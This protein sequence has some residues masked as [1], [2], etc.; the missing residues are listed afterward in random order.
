M[1][2]HENEPQF[3]VPKLLFNIR[4][5]GADPSR[6][7][8]RRYEF[9]A[10]LP[11]DPVPA[12]RVDGRIVSYAKQPGRGI[13]RH[14]M[15]RPCLQS[16]EHSFLHGLLGQFEMSRSEEPRQVGQY[17]PRLMPEQV[18]QQVAMF[19]RRV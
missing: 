10:L 13:L 7:V 6:L 14:S 3:V 19:R 12:N 9:G 4:I 5:A 17:P 18:L 1:A 16:A 11:S 2:A 15:I 8:Q